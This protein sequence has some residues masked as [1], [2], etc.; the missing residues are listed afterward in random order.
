MCDRDSV[1]RNMADGVSRTYRSE[2]FDYFFGL[3][4]KKVEL[5]N[6]FL[7]GND[8]TINDITDI[9]LNRPMERGVANDLGLQIGNNVIFLLEAQST[10]PYNGF[11]RMLRYA[12]TEIMHRLEDKTYYTDKDDFP[13]VYLFILYSEERVKR[14]KEMRLSEIIGDTDIDMT[15]H[16]VYGEDSSEGPVFEY[17]SFIREFTE[18][19]GQCSTYAETIDLTIRRC[20]EKGILGD[21][22]N[23]HRGDLMNLLD[24]M[25]FDA[26]KNR[27]QYEFQLIEG[28]REDGEYRGIIKGREEGREE[29]RLEMQY[30]IARNCLM[31]GQSPDMVAR[32][33]GLDLETVLRIQSEYQ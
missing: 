22:L 29:G 21:F 32:I 4:E 19:I 13:Q 2:F 33:T 9:T 12:Y 1:Q 8:Y 24:E 25:Y 14:P 27:A 11:L 17:V 18:S 16:F 23:E 6:T 20:T 7:P 28:A 3:D 15:I 5:V 30:E 26:E 10:W 31:D